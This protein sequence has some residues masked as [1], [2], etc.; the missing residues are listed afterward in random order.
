SDASSTDPANLAE[1]A[2]IKELLVKALKKLPEAERQVVFLYYNR[3]LL[4]REIG[5]VL[6]VS[7]SRVC[8]ILG[9][10]HFLL[11]KEIENMGG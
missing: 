7:E 3:N 6:N 9:R 4:L 8:Q 2:E 11:N 10:A 5:E 1:N